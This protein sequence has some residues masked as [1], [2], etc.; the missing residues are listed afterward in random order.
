MLTGEGMSRLIC[1]HSRGV[2]RSSTVWVL[3]WSLDWWTLLKRPAKNVTNRPPPCKMLST[4]SGWGTCMPIN[5]VCSISFKL[6]Q[7][8]YFFIWRGG[9]FRCL[10][11]FVFIGKGISYPDK[12]STDIKKDNPNLLL[13]R[14]AGI[15][16]FSFYEIT[17]LEYS[18]MYKSIMHICN[19]EPDFFTTLK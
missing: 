11:L 15:P 2:L 5:S 9:G 13:Y 8:A 14:C 18:Y 16:L 1:P 19:S 10:I 3:P 17:V 4:N 12:H 7:H 6:I